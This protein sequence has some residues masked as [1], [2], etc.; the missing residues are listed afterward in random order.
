MWRASPGILLRDDENELRAETGHDCRERIKHPWIRSRDIDS[1]ER[2][3]PQHL[4]VQEQGRCEL[5]K[6]EKRPQAVGV[7]VGAPIPST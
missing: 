3:S 5:H 6:C 4:Q 1:I 2:R 7:K